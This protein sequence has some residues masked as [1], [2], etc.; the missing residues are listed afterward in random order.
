MK[1]DYLLSGA[2][3]RGLYEDCAGL[4]I[5]DYHCHLPPKDIYEDRVFGNIGELWLGG[6][7]YKWRLM[8]EA[9]FPEELITGT[10]STY[11]EKF[12]AYL[13]ALEFA[14]GNPLYAWSGMELKQFFGV[15]LPLT[16]ANADA[17]WDACNKVIEERQ[18]SPRKLIRQ[19][20]VRLVATTDDPA[21]TLEWHRLLAADAEKGFEVLPSFRPDKALNLVAPGYAEYLAKLA[22]A[23][24][25]G[26][27]ATLDD[28]RAALRARLDF[29]QSMGCRITDVGLADFPDAIATDAEADAVFRKAAAGQPV[30]RGEFLA[31]LGNAYVFL[32]REYK[33]R[34]MVM[35]WHLAAYR[36]ANT[37]L[38]KALGPDCGCDCIGDI[39]P[40]RDLVRVLDAIHTGGGLPQTILYALEPSMNSALMTLAGSY[41]PVRLGAAWWFVDHRRGIENVLDIVA[42]T[43]HLGSFLGMLTDSRSF[44]SY[45]RHDYFRRILASFV[46]RLVDNGEYEASCA[47]E[48]L[49][50]IC[51][52]NIAGLLGLD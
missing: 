41:G 5:Y 37:P 2:T 34:G 44:L 46:A 28:F 17:I 12:R 52:G 32:G 33:A 8:R 39:V 45:A 11:Q 22:A 40:V 51:C 18:L 49:R 19:S 35:Q 15:E 21:D 9:G 29:F 3:A 1:S 36:N 20:N 4:P 27:I 7:H 50:R 25:T 16:A 14:A 30:A 43:G 10:A 42:E 24:G 23:A 47:P 48:L 31:F 13:S 38:F 6:D 26:P